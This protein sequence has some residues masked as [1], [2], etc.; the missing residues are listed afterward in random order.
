MDSLG[1]VE[2]GGMDRPV[3]EQKIISVEVLNKRDHAY[4]VK[5]L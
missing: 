1:A 3:K 4:E 2:T 5:K